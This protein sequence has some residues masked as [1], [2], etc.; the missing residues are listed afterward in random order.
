MDILSST[1]VRKNWSVTLDSVVHNKPAYIK[2]THDYIALIEVSIMNRI[3]EG[4]RFYTDVLIESDG[5]V[6]LI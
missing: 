6:F 2:H 1:D 5:S 3:L 4:Y